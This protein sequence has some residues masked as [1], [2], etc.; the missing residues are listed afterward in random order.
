M[1]NNQ[2]SY[3]PT[4]VEQMSND[5]I[6]RREFL[7]KATLL[8]VSAATAYSLAGLAMPG[9]AALADDMPKG[10]NLR[11]GMRCMEIKDP[12]LADFAEKSNVI[13]QVCEYLTLTCL[14]YTSP[15]P[16]D[17]TR[18]RMPSSA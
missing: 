10:G 1:D 16:R 13:R 11:I 2:H 9:D 12:H 15:S 18:S 8:G 6:G 14:L 17:R 4:L 5:V 3:I 7:R